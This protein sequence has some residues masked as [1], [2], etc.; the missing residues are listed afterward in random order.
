MSGGKGHRC[1][2]T[3]VGSYNHDEF[4]SEKSTGGDGRGGGEAS[5]CVGG[6]RLCEEG[7]CC[8]FRHGGGVT[9]MVNFAGFMKYCEKFE[10]KVQVVLSGVFVAKWKHGRRESW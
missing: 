5:C 3:V 10:E 1:R 2:R 8:E 4:V 6:S 9:E 7:C